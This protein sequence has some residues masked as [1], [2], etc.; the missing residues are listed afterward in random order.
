MQ[1][2]KIIDIMHIDTSKLLL[3]IIIIIIQL[4]HFIY[5]KAYSHLELF[6]FDCNME[7]PISLIM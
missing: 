6:I 7:S 3:I 1:K 2:N 5:Y 4:I